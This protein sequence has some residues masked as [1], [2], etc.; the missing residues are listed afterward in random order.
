M[1]ATQLT[2]EHVRSFSLAKLFREHTKKINSLQFDPSGEYCITASEDESLQVYDALQGIHKNTIYSKKYGVDHVHYLPLH[3][4]Q[5]VHSSTKTEDDMI[6]LLS[7]VENRYLRYFRG[8]NTRVVSLAMSPID[9]VFLSG[10]LNESIRVWDIRQGSCVGAV[11]IRGRPCLTIDPEGLV[12]A[13]GLAP[14][15][16]LYDMKSYEKGPFATYTPLDRLRNPP[17]MNPSTSSSSMNDEYRRTLDETSEYPDYEWCDLQFS[18]D[19][20]YLLISTFGDRLYLID[21][22]D[23]SLIRTFSGYSN[24]QRLPLR[25]SWTPDVQFVLCSS[26][27]GDLYVWETETGRLITCLNSHS[28]EPHLV[29][30]N[31]RYMMMA[32][33]CSN[34]EFWI[35]TVESL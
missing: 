26:E 7:L 11:S 33:A 22:F 13:I 31:P 28:K 25:G 23:G 27:E 5:V 15:I 19:G 12:F 14:K 16:R 21:A 29:Q 6:R 3:S 2:D 20:R 9:E 34:L 1:L 18:N 24:S 10:S 35:P 32:T 17:T 8:H 30:F 4:T